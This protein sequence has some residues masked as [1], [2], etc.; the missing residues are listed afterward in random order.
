AFGDVPEDALSPEHLSLG[1]ADGGF[2]DADVNRLAGRGDV[3]FER[4]EGAP[5]SD[6]LAVVLLIFGGQ[7]DRVKIKV[8][9][10]NDLLERFAEKLAEALVGERETFSE[11]LPENVLGQMLDEGMVEGLARNQLFLRVLPFDGVADGAPEQVRFQAA[12][13]K[14]ILRAF[15]H[16]TQ[17]ELFIVDAAEDDNG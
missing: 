11:I 13:G 15:A 8:G 14:V 4:F 16:G 9:F 17:G 5:G 3:A 6:H 2:N 10:A 7:L 12:L 1:V